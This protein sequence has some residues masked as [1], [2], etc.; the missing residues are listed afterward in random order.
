MEYTHTHTHTH[1]H[2]SISKVWS[3]TV[4]KHRRLTQGTKEIKNYI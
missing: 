3:A 4:I 1:T 2:T